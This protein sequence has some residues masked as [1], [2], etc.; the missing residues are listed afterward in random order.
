MKFPFRRNRDTTSVPAE[1]QEYYQAERRDRTGVA[2]LLALGTLIITIGLATLLFFGGRWAYR[3]IVDND[4]NTETAQTEEE[5]TESDSNSPESSPA[6][7][8]GQTGPSTGTSSTTT[9][10]PNSPTPTEAGT[11]STAQSTTPATG[12]NVAGSTT[13]LPNT[14]AGDIVS[15]FAITTAVGA[16]AHYAI[17]TRRTES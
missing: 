6:T 11:R 10:T 12:S 5:S 17:T 15:I 3:T 16:A 9:S 1:I 2:W 14:G 4:N 7:E 13:D 8:S